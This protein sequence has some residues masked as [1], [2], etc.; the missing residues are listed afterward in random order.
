MQK[1]SSARCSMAP[2]KD[3][4]RA[5]MHV[6]ENSAIMSKSKLPCFR[7]KSFPKEAFA[8][9]KIA[10]ELG[11]AAKRSRCYTRVPQPLFSFPPSKWRCLVNARHRSS[12]IAPFARRFYERIKDVFYHSSFLSNSC[13]DAAKSRRDERRR[14]RTRTIQ[15]GTKRSST[16]ESG[17][18]S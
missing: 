14:W 7:D 9:Q 2:G 17:G 10:V 18:Q 4:A 1:V 15:S 3:F 16:T 8:S 11:R 5:F 6:G 13:P 12:G